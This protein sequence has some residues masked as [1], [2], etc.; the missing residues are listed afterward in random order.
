ML[1][2]IDNDN[3]NNSSSSSRI[4][5]NIG[6]QSLRNCIVI[7]IIENEIESGTAVDEG[8][9]RSHKENTRILIQAYSF[10]LRYR[11]AGLSHCI[12]ASRIAMRGGMCAI[13]VGDR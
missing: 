11:A 10:G 4:S 5:V 2:C 12:Y 9:R 1:R 6:I 3:N 7:A 8:G 13:Y